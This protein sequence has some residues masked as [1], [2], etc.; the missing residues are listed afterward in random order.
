MY[1]R[2]VATTDLNKNTEWFT[3]PGVWITYMLLILFSWIIVLSL[4]ACSPGIAWTIVHLFHF[5]VCFSFYTY[6]S[7][8]SNLFFQSRI[9]GFYYLCYCSL[10]ILSLIN[11]INL[12][13]SSLLVSPKWF[14]FL[15]WMFPHFLLLSILICI[16]GFRFV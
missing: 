3:Y 7:S 9:L 4:F 12:S 6:I 11:S 8:F 16:F 5:L 14:L 1:V 10:P 13:S 2:A 15:I